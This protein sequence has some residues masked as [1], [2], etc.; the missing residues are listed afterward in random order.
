MGTQNIRRR[1]GFS[2]VELAIVLV[3]I[4]LILSSVLVGQDIIKA[5]EL[6][7]I[8][9]QYNGI[10]TAYQTFATR[11]QNKIPGDIYNLNNRFGF[12]TGPECDSTG[13]GLGDGDGLVESA[14]G[15]RAKFDGEIS[16]FWGHLSETNLIAGTYD[17]YEDTTASATVN[18]VLEENLPRVRG[19][20]TGWGVFNASSRNY[21]I[22]GVTGAQADDAFATSGTF[23]PKDAADIDSKVDDGL[24]LTGSIQARD[25]AA[26]EPNT[27]DDPSTCH[28]NGGDTVPS[29]DAYRLA[30]GTAE[31]DLIFELPTI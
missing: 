22:A 17:G 12:T 13:D 16:C 14:A 31:C 5:A 9:T 28:D 11:Y 2:L 10:R 20:A 27:I 26:A 1:Q 19:R 4:G 23:T 15:G 24:P 30:T 25:P 18:D 3:I 8:T 7:A 29:N 21:L 6:R